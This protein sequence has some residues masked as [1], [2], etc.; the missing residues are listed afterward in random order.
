MWQRL[1]NWLAMTR[2]EQRVILF[3]STTL[4]VGA[5]IRLYQ[6]TYPSRREFDY[7]AVDSSFAAF[8]KEL[9]PDSVQQKTGRPG[10]LVNIN[11]ASKDELLALPGIGQTLAERIVI[12]RGNQRKF[13]SAEDLQKVE[14]ISKKKFEKL[15]PFVTVQ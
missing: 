1:T 3:L 12:F 15:K 11:T 14:G 6:E 13:G 10:K 5:G 2:S 8:R 9:A 4:V 7:R